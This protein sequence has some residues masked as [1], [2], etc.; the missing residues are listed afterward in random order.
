MK[1]VVVAK[2]WDDK[3]KAQIKFI[4]GE[5]TEYINAKLFMKAYNEHYH[6][7]AEIKEID[8]EKL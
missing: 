6:A 3:K 7:N 4:A 1:Y 2:R 5:F 8:P